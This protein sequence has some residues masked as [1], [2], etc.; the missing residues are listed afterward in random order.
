MPRT[1][2]PRFSDDLPVSKQV[3]DRIRSLILDGKLPAGTRLPP[4]TDLARESGTS[5]FTVQTA[6]ARLCR[7]GLLE[8]K[9]KLGTFVSSNAVR[10]A[11]IGFYFGSGIWQHKEMAFTQ[12]VYLEVRKQLELRD[13]R[14]RVWID[15]R[16]QESQTNAP[17]S[18]RRAIE[19]REIQALVALSCNHFDLEW[20]SRLSIPISCMSGNLALKQR[21]GTDIAQ[22]IA[23]GLDQLHK[24]GCRK[25]GFISCL[26]MKAT[27]PMSGYGAGGIY[28]IFLDKAREYGFK[29]SN[30]W[31]HIP[32]SYVDAK[33][34]FGWEKFHQTWSSPVRPDGL[35]VWPDSAVRGVI[36]AV[37]AK[38]VSVPQELQLAFHIN[39]NVPCPCPF[40]CIQ[41]VIDEAAL[42]TGIIQ[43][44]HTQLRGAEVEPFILKH[45]LRLHSGNFVESLAR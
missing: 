39:E 24:Q 32:E 1:P 45:K 11:S 25:V 18:L 37:L 26:T 23:I 9:P 4:N 28:N 29:I 6:L 22:C 5:S 42:A 35:L 17:K 31:T 40:P 2:E 36:S 13:V 30:D 34:Q 33:E 7:E 16:P 8:R 43:M 38:G 12:N 20:I 44:L 14:S 21:I 3:E 27:S 15:D 41:M 10:L 19:H